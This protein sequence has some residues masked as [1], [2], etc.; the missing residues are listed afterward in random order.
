MGFA[1]LN[2]SYALHVEGAQAGT[3][4]PCTRGRFVMIALDA[5][6]KPA[7]VAPLAAADA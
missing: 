4:H 7:S 1:A 6:G 2:P 3:C 5:N